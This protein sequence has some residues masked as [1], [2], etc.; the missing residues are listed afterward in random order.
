MVGLGRYLI[1][2]GVVDRS[3]LMCQH[4]ERVLDIADKYG[5]HCQMWSDMFFKLMSADGQ[6]DRDVEIPEET[7]VFLD[8]LKDR[9][10]LVYWDYYQDS[11]EKYNRNFGNHHKISQDIAFAGGA[12]KWIGFTP[13]NHFS[14]L[15]AIEANKSCRANQIKEVIVTGWGDNGG[16]TAQFSI[17]PSLTNLG[18]TQLSK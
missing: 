7:R 12:W 17:L 3:L 1:L 9:V 2:N 5:F 11:E 4:L 13:H 16:E 15:I 8:R 10:T 6:Y 14:R 18:R